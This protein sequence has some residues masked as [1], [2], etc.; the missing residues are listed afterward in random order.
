MFLPQGLCTYGSL[1]L[2]HLPPIW[3]WFIL[4]SLWLS[5][6]TFPILNVSP[7]STSY[8]LSLSYFFH[9]IYYN[10]TSEKHTMFLFIFNDPCNTIL[11]AS[12]LKA[13]IFFCLVHSSFPSVCQSI[14]HVWNSIK[15]WMNEW[16][17]SSNQEE[18][19]DFGFIVLAEATIKQKKI[20]K[21]SLLGI[22]HEGQWSLGD[23]KQVLTISLIFCFCRVLRHS[24]GKNNIN[25][26]GEYKFA[27]QES[28]GKARR[29]EFSDRVPDGESGTNGEPERLQRVLLRHPL[30][31]NQ[32]MRVTK[33]PGAKESAAPKEDR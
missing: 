23:R 29:L 8:L 6:V 32:R 14:L 19:T 10:L 9:A 18:V 3:T 7:V 25:G 15:G 22:S 24:S 4:L 20:W 27:F 30:S 17:C 1:C 28:S 2:K 31:A 11:N 21:R 16:D 26:G 13:G 33:P 12:H 5:S